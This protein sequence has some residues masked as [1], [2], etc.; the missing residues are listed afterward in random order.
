MT[1]PAPRK[2]Q[3]NTTAIASEE[4]KLLITKRLLAADRERAA[5]VLL[6]LHYQL[7]RTTA[8]IKVK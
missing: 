6:Q 8:S 5:E 4:Q 2:L 7:S 3:D 1:Q